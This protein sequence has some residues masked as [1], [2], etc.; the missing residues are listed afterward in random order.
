MLDDARSG[1][2]F[3]SLKGRKSD[4]LLIR[5]YVKN[6]T[7]VSRYSVLEEGGLSGH[8]GS[9]KASLCD[10]TGWCCLYN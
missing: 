5:G 3:F 1:Q 6:R 4:T 2:L 9:L 7:V 8:T 10:E